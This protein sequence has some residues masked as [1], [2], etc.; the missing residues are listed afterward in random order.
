M[1]RRSFPSYPRMR[2]NSH[3][4]TLTLKKE[5]EKIATLDE[6]GNRKWQDN[7]SWFEPTADKGT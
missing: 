5:K 4:H 3:H 6:M 2:G 1:N 7:K